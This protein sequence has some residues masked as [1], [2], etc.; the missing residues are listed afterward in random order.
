VLFNNAGVLLGDLTNSK[1]ANE[2]H[3]QVNTLAPYML[4]RLLRPQFAAADRACIVNVSS[5]AIAMTGSLRID[6]LRQPPKLKKIFG[7][8]AQSK[9]ALTT[10]THA[11]APEYEKEGII[12]RSL[13]PGAIKTRMT[14][15]SGMPW[16][17]LLLCPLFFQTPLKGAKAIYAAA[18]DSKFGNQSGIFINNGK[19]TSPPKDALDLNIQR[20][21]LM[22]C[23]DLTG[24]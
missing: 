17:L 14:A 3:F 24:L 15:S 16:F 6:E 21:L 13:D 9:L 18:F 2:M 12:L 23:Q 7:A 4:M 5:D 10:L 8:Y 19:I 22:L 20:S 1:H 11:I